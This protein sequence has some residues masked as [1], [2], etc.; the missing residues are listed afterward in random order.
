MIFVDGENLAIRY[1]K[2]LGGGN[3]AD[4]VL[5]EPDVYVWSDI[6]RQALHRWEIIPI[7]YFTSA[8][9]DSDRLHKIEDDLL[10]GGVEAPRVFKKAK[11]MRGK[12]VDISLATE[13]LSHAHRGNFDAAVLVAGDGDY[14]PLV[15]AVIREGRRVIGWFV[16]DGLNDDLRRSVDFFFDIS[17]ILMKNREGKDSAWMAAFH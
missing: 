13:M 9:G 16:R 5:V 1:G 11:G 8:T 3:P 14:V 4:H 6:L 15:E 2:M 7:Y 12:E 10:K 17:P